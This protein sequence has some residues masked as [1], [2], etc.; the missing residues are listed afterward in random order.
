MYTYIL[1][2]FKLINDLPTLIMCNI[3]TLCKKVEDRVSD[4]FKGLCET[5]KGEVDGNKAAL[6]ARIE[7]ETRD[8]V[9]AIQ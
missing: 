6:E 9:V 2:L 5:V 3:Q 8:R 4:I 7:Q 1:Q